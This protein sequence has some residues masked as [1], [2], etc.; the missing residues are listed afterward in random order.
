[1]N[2]PASKKGWTLWKAPRSGGAAPTLLLSVQAG[3]F[4]SFALDAND[5][6]FID[7]YTGLNKISKNGGA[8]TNIAYADEPGNFLVADDERLYWLKDEVLT[9]TCK[10]GSSSQALTAETYLTEDLA[11]DDSGIY[12]TQFYQVWKIAK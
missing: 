8:V 2:Q 10:D 4:R 9:A 7:Y 1:M 5:I 3:R 6:Y 12:W 11:V